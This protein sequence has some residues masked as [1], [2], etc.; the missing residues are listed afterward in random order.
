[1]RQSWSEQLE[2]SFDIDG[3][4]FHSASGHP[5]KYIQLWLMGEDP[6]I[7]NAVYED[8][9]LFHKKIKL[10]FLSYSGGI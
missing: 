7:L 9:N 4:L 3:T 5:D 2:S 6:A 1:M 8:G 10:N